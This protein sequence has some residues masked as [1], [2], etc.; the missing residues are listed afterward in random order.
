MLFNRFRKRKIRRFRSRYYDWYGYKIQMQEARE[1]FYPEYR[2]VVAD[3]MTGKPL[4]V[5]M[6]KES[7]TSM[8]KE[9]ND[10]NIKPVYVRELESD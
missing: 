4:W 10:A 9:Y 2:Y 1:K 8:A 6:D 3:V 7:A 5:C